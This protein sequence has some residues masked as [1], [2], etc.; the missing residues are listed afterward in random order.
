MRVA[1]RRRIGPGTVIDS[2]A[3]II[4]TLAL[5]GCGASDDADKSAATDPKTA[6]AKAIARGEGAHKLLNP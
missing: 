5:A 6:K 2:I 3:V 4:L 1:L